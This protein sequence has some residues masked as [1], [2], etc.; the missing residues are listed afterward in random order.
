M[1]STIKEYNMKLS[2]ALFTIQLTQYV[3]N[4]LSVPIC[5]QRRRY[6]LYLLWQRDLRSHLQGR[7]KWKILK[8]T[9]EG[10]S[11]NNNYYVC[12]TYI[13]AYKYTFHKT[14]I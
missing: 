4:I 10:I 14:R 1:T 11:Q 5:Y 3:K 6:V 13:V 2:Q 9:T 7:N 8:K 12:N